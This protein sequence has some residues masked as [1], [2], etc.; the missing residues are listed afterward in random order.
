MLLRT[1]PPD[2]M[3]TLQA[4][5]LGH[6]IFLTRTADGTA[7]YGIGGVGLETKPGAYPLTFR[8]RTKT[9]QEITFLKKTTVQAGKYR[10]IEIRVP[11]QF[12]EPTPE[13]QKKINEDKLV[14]QQVFEHMGPDREWT[15]SFRAPVQA[16]TSDVFGTRRTFNGS[17][18]SVHQGLDFAVPEGVPVSALNRGKV[19]LAQFLFFEGNCVVIDHG[20]GLLTLYLHLSKIDVKEGDMV[21]RGQRIGASGGTGRATGPHLHIAVRWQ[22][23]YL[24]PA[25]LLQLH[26]P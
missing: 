15:G 16:R 1:V 2:P 4:S 24:D 10:T 6:Q 22:G 11:K 25:T 8:G 20:Q 18:R 13:Q 3:D 12:T 26:L 21:E 5:W 17:V 7:W 23:T 19:L 9:G 14:K